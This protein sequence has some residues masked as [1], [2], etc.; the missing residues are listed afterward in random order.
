MIKITINNCV[1]FVHPVYDLYASDENGNIIHILKKIP[2]KGRKTNNGYVSCCVRKHGDKQKTHQVHRFV[3]ECFNG[4]IPEGKVINH[5]NNNKEDNRLCNL[6]L[7][8]HQQ[9]CKKSAKNRDYSFNSQNHKN[10]KC[11]KATNKNT[12]EVTYYNSMSAIQQHIGINAG[13]V[14]MVCEGLNHCKSGKSKKDGHSYTFEYI[15]QDDLPDDCKKSA[16]IRPKRVSDEDKKKN[17]IETIKKWQKKEFECKNCGK[18]FYSDC[19]RLD[20]EPLKFTLAM[21]LGDITMHVE[22]ITPVSSI[23]PASEIV[24]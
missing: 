14:K 6:Q 13:I 15:K 5:L 11:V 12:N 22:C 7:L 19:L 23:L 3:W 1:Y 24:T 2:N 9:N 16:N 21:K 10:R 4:V 17:Q 20:P 18:V 8:T